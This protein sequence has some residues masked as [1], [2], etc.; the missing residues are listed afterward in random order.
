MAENREKSIISLFHSQHIDEGQLW[1][2]QNIGVTHLN[3]LINIY[4]Y[5]SHHIGPFEP[6]QH[7]NMTTSR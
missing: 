1:E 3:I 5:I 7:T 6:I 2:E 4:I